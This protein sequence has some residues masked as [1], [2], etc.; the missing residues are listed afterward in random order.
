M[1]ADIRFPLERA[2]GVQIVKTAAALARGGRAHDAAG[3]PER[4]AAD[5]RDPGPLRRR[6]AARL[7]VRRLRVCHRAGAFA[8]P[9]AS[10]PGPRHRSSALRALRRGARRLH[11]RPPARR[12]CC[13]ALPAGARA[14]CTRRTRWRRSCTAS[15]ARSTARG[16]APN[17]RK[18]RA[19]ARAREGARVAA[20]RRL[21]DHHRRHPRQL[22]ARPT[23]TARRVHVVP[24]RLRR[25]ADRAFPG[26]PAGEPPRVALRRPALSLEGRRRAGGGHGAACPAARLV[27][28]GGLEG[29][30]DT[31]A[32][33]RA[34]G[35]AAGLAAR[36]EMP[37]T[38]P[39]GARGGRAARARPWSRCRS[40]STA[41]TERHTSPLKAFEAMAAGPA[42]R[43]LRPAVARRE[44]L[45]DGENALL[46]PPGDAR[47]AG[48]GAAARC[49]T[50]ATL[51]ERLA[52]AAL[53]RRAPRT[54][55]TRGPRR[56]SALF[57]EVR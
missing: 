30:A 45:R 35:S 24:E 27:I 42:D 11:A 51:A 29:E 2:N 9:R 20:R 43:G 32:R 44:V 10:L 19:A 4:P 5:A 18:A 25:P 31:G 47:R 14:W 50:I 13:C 7:E 36:T 34:R 56:S 52:R 6:A 48:R 17:A 28:L 16:E 21:R 22:R 33:A 55:G 41:M 39:A 49:W 40:C 12:R 38:G 46:V 1:P 57:A 54:P 23:A 15:A 53:C 37:G 3:A 8:L 26:L